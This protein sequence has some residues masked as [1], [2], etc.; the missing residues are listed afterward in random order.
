MNMHVDREVLAI[1]LPLW[2]FARCARDPFSALDT[3]VLVRVS[4]D[5]KTLGVQHPAR[6]QSRSLDHL[7][8]RTKRI[9]QLHLPRR[10]T[11]HFRQF[12]IPD[13][14]HECLCA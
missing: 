3:R 5:P 6:A 4:P 8:I 14:N 9:H 13:E 2:P 7:Q 1:A 12:W 10:F 11:A